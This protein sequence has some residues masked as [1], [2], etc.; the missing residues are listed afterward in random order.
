M[1]QYSTEIKEIKKVEKIIC[2]KCGKVIPVT[3]G[4]PQEDVL[5]VEK[6]WGYHSG[7]DNQVDCFDLCEDCY[8]ELVDSFLIKLEKPR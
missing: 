7:K 8:D 1:R 3:E 6:R 5:E 2:N 4:I